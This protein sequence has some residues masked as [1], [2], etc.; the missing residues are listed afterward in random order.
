[1]FYQKYVKRLLDLLISSFS[2]LILWPVF[3]V[4]AIFI[5]IDSKGRVFFKQERLGKD[6]EVFKIYKFRTMVEN[7]ENIGTGLSTFE[8]DPRVTKVG[9]LLRKTS[10]DE[11]PQLINIIKGDMSLIGPRP[12]VPYSPKK[13]DEY[14]EIQRKRFTVR[15]GITGLAQV[16]GRN[17]LTWEERIDFDVKYVKQLRF[18]LDLK[19]LF[20]T[21]IRVFKRS[22]IHGPERRKPKGKRKVN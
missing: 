9:N 22:D 4:I 6:G 14:S 19:I 13:Y 16:N 18:G 3:V 10:L 21:I 15:P 11:L 17:S 12:P 1:M 20:L 2:L 8:G 7:A 5:K